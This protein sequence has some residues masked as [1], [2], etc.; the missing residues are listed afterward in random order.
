MDI[1]KLCRIDNQAG[2]FPRFKVR[3]YKPSWVYDVPDIKNK[4]IIELKILDS[5]F[6]YIASLDTYVIIHTGTSSSLEWITESIYWNSFYFPD[7][8]IPTILGIF[9]EDKI[10]S[11]SAI[12]Q[13]LEERLFITE[14]SL[15]N[16]SIENTSCVFVLLTHMYKHCN[17][18]QFEHN[19]HKPPSKTLVKEKHPIL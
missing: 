1:S 15:C 11:L 12:V 4:S 17:N 18:L 6:K 5:C 8:K 2:V 3:K 14:Q 13:K 7:E 16:L 9:G 10:N 19:G